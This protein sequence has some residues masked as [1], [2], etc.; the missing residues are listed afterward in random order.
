MNVKEQLEK[1]A[2]FDAEYKILMEDKRSGIGKILT[3]EIK[4]Q[5]I[6]VDDYFASALA[7]ITK[8]ITDMEATIKAAVIKNGESVKG[9]YTASYVKGRVSWN[10]KALDGYAAAHPEIKE[11]KKIGKPSARIKR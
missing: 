11:F 6:E 5:L 10:D 9:V 7:K 3:E 8:Q 4:E 2:K 1:L